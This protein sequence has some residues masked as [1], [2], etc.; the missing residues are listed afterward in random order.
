MTRVIG[1]LSLVAALALA[2]CS[3][4]TKTIRQETVRTVPVPAAPVVVEKRTT[5]I[6]PEP[7]VIEKRT[8][9]ETIDPVVE[10]RTTTTIESEY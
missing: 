6:E 7:A 9:V 2:G 10:K 5:V 8:T 3:S 4:E 1:G